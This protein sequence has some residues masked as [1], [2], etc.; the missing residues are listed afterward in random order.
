VL[1]KQWRQENVYVSHSKN[2]LG[3]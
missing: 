2:V 3:K 1:L